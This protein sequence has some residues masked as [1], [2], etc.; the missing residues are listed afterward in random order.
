MKPFMK[1]K[2]FIL[3]F[4]NYYFFSFFFWYRPLS[5]TYFIDT[6]AS[7]QPG[8]KAVSM[9]VPCIEYYSDGDPADVISRTISYSYTPLT[10]FWEKR[11]VGIFGI[12]EFSLEEQ[13]DK[14]AKNE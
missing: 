13:I 14:E 12:D 4:M 10:W 11:G 3:I 1:M 9:F 8:P 2:L 6:L 7:L 5:P